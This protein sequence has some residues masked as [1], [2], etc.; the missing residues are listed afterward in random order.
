MK[1]KFNQQTKVYYP[2][3]PQ[4]DRA[5]FQHCT[6]GRKEITKAELDHY[7]P[8]FTAHGVELEFERELKPLKVIY[9]VSDGAEF[10]RKPNGEY[11]QHIDGYE[12]I[13]GTPFEA[14]DKY[15]FT[16]KP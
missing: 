8:V 1:L 14:F 13:T 4:I 2:N 5:L 11:Y 7:F 10:V 3:N 12:S 9:R 16:S 15:N 6:E